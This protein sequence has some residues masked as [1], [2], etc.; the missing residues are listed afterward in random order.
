MRRALRAA[1][2]GFA[3]GIGVS[4][5]FGYAFY[6]GCPIFDPILDRDPTYPF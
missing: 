2:A 6:R 3:T 4:A 5:V 1:A